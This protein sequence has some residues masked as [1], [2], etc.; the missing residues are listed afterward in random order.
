MTVPVGQN[1]AHI[2]QLEAGRLYDIILVAEKGTS[3]SE[4]AATQV[5]PGEYYQSFSEL[6][7]SMKCYFSSDFSRFKTTEEP[8]LLDRC[9]STF[10]LKS[11]M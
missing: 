6:L 9:F 1:S 3:R 5:T 11:E 10:C 2:Q 4:P 7:R 8:P